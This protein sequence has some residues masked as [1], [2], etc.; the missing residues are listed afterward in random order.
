MRQSNRANEPKKCDSVVMMSATHV[1][2]Y[3]TLLLSSII[4]YFYDPPYFLKSSSLTI[5]TT[6]LTLFCTGL[7]WQVCLTCCFNPNRVISLHQ[8]RRTTSNGIL[9]IPSM[10]MLSGIGIQLIRLNSQSVYEWRVLQKHSNTTVTAA[11]LHLRSGY[12]CPPSPAW[13]H[14][15][16]LVYGITLFF[17]F[18]HYLRYRFEIRELFEDKFC[19]FGQRV[20]TAFE[21]IMI[22]SL[23]F[24]TETKEIIKCD[25]VDQQTILIAIYCLSLFPLVCM[26]RRTQRVY[27]RG[28][29]KDKSRNRYITPCLDLVCQDLPFFVFRAV[30]IA[31]SYQRFAA[32]HTDFAFF[33]NISKFTKNNLTSTTVIF[34]IKNFVSMLVAIKEILHVWRSG[35]S[36][37]AQDFSLN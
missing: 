13:V 22:D 36:A 16:I 9:T 15:Q 19:W 24:V 5:F 35:K 2:F 29:L 3:M 27:H 31:L 14:K 20:L 21:L 32:Y 4:T 17:P 23:E 26:V 25:D 11:S 12:E 30:V 37:G 28:E 7:V 6:E 18:Y 1:I 33:A 8:Q 34:M 10:F